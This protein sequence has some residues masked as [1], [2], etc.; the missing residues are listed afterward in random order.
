[1]VRRELG[2]DSLLILLQ[3]ILGQLNTKTI[4]WVTANTSL[5]QQNGSVFWLQIA[6]RKQYNGLLSILN[7][8]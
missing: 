2:Y 7:V 6:E 4:Q 8:M 5:E 1:M 3:Y